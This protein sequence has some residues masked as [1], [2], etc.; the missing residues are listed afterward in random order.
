[1]ADI[2]QVKLPNGDTFDLV[3]EKSGYTKNTGTITSVK[4]T[5]GQHTTINVT[6]G[7]A[8]FNV[9]THTSHLTNDS[10]YK[11]FH[12]VEASIPLM[13]GTP[14]IDSTYTQILNWIEAGE[15][16]IIIN[17]Q[18]SDTRYYFHGISNTVLMFYSLSGCELD[19]KSNDIRHY[20][21]SWITL[22]DLPI[23]DGTV[24]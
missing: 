6:S 14:T 2:S 13:G 12:V 19:I 17:T 5:A 8:N 20:G 9:P 10:G 16:V 11:K 3:D 4:T 1:M 7:A 24:E 18:S 15:E 23:Y 21:P 22:E